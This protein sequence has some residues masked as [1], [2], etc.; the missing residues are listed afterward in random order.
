MFKSSIIS[1]TGNSK[2]MF[3]ALLLHLHVFI[4]EVQLA[5]SS[6]VEVLFLMREELKVLR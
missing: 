3:E 6:R 1:L 5:P 2:E 4:D